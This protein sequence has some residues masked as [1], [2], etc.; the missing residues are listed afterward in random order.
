M[1]ESDKKSTFR[2]FLYVPAQSD[3]I[4]FNRPGLKTHTIY[5]QYCISN[6]NK[7][8]RYMNFGPDIVWFILAISYQIVSGHW[9][10]R[11]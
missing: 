11:V 6:W 4:F 3:T 7:K 10:M 1:F 5:S 9:L 2:A 8:T